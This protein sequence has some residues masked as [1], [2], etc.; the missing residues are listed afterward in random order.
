MTSQSS[1]NNLIIIVGAGI[2]GSALAA[3]L[4]ED[5]SNGPI[6][7]IDRSFSEILGSTSYAPGFLGQY[8]ES[9]VLTKL[10]VDSLNGY[11]RFPKVF[12][13]VGGLELAST[14][15]G[16]DKLKDRCTKAQ[17]AGLSARFLTEE[18]MSSVVPA[19]VNRQSFTK[20]LYFDTDG[21][22]DPK[23]LCEM[24][25]DL[26]R[27][28]G[29][30]IL[31]ENIKDTV[32]EDG[33]VQGVKT[34]TGEIIE[35]KSVIYSTGIW[36]SSLLQEAVQMPVPAV[37]VAHPYVYTGEEDARDQT[38][39]CRWPEDHVYA[40][41]HGN[42]YGIGSYAHPP[43]HVKSLDSTASKEWPQ[44]EFAHVI[45]HA[46]ASKVSSTSKLGELADTKTL[47]DDNNNM[48]KINGIFSVTPDNL[49]LLGHVPG[50]DNLW[51]ATG[52]WITH[53]AGCA[54][55]LA[56]MVRGE[57][58]DQS[59]AQALDPARFVADDS[60]DLEATALRQYNDIYRSK[61]GT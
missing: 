28:N 32:I 52:I 26:A 14:V 25:R 2:V 34:N 17:H 30:K 54:R 49:P 8:N 53:A 36:T 59:I 23:T 15:D 61:L 56:R 24:Y 11:D 18:D 35:A 16:I 21:V 29:V 57:E 7:L 12:Q 39:F 42:R 38:P 19:F 40:R 51:L 41:D 1:E 47:S 44:S 48:K 31:E 5:R 27:Q 43:V 50:V 20:A 60:R 55:L 9:S 58:H 10:A 37:P 22:A 46:T 6:L 13:R 3:Y 33:T 4:S 45:A